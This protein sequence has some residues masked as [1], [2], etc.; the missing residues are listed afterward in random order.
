MASTSSTKHHHIKDTPL[1]GCGCIDC[2]MSLPWLPAVPPEQQHDNGLLPSAAPVSRIPDGILG[3]AQNA[4]KE[5][6]AQLLNKQNNSEADHEAGQRITTR[7]RTVSYQANNPDE[8]CRY[9]NTG[10]DCASWLSHCQRAHICSN[11]QSTT[12]GAHGCTFNPSSLI[13]GSYMT[14]ANPT[15]TSHQQPLAREQVVMCA[16][17]PPDGPLSTTTNLV[18]IPQ[19]LTAA[20]LTMY[21]IPP[22]RAPFSDPRTGMPMYFVPTSFNPSWISSDTTPNRPTR[23]CELHNRTSGCTWSECHRQHICSNCHSPNHTLP[24]CTNYPNH[25]CEKFNSECGCLFL[26]C[27]RRH[28]CSNCHSSAHSVFLCSNYPDFVCEKFNG[29]AGCLWVGCKRRHVCGKC[30]K[31]GHGQAVC[32]GV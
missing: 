10:I 26:H 22:P 24:A 12:H 4:T 7:D 9:F 6:V 23:I 16:T 1:S 5:M 2:I 29:T 3:S 27:Q 20:E 28:V 30:G 8:V 32:E 18:T 25:V 11:C 14:S 31:E 15:P 21:P 19:A 17:S 13:K